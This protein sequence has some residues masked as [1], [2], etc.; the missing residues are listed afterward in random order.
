[1]PGRVDNDTQCKIVDF[2]SHSVGLESQDHDNLSRLS[3][4]SDLDCVTQ[5]TLV[6]ELKKLLRQAQAR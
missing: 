2:V 6:V 5:E 1:M 4:E 3:S